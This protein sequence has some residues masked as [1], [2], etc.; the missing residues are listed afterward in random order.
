L[1]NH[2][3]IAVGKSAKEALHRTVI[4]EEMAEI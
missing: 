4:L 3:T 2:G 1:Q